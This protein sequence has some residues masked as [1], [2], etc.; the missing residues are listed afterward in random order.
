M[1][2]GQYISKEVS[3]RICEGERFGADG[4][5]IKCDDTPCLS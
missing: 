4:F 1:N 5:P 3:E 2:S